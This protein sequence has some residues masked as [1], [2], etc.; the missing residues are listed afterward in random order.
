MV[1]KV[2]KKTQPEWSNKIIHKPQLLSMYGVMFN[3][4]QKSTL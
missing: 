2:V 3:D 4:P 1:L